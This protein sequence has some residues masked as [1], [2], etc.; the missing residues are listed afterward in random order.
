[1]KSLTSRGYVRRQYCWRHN[2]WYLNEEGIEYLREFLHLPNDVVP[3]THKV[4]NTA[5]ARGDVR[6][7]GEFRGGKDNGP[8]RGFQ[9]RFRGGD[10]N[11]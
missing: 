11:F 2:Y 7:G 4:E 6:M 1:M 10:R 8:N 9:P 5:V 3:I